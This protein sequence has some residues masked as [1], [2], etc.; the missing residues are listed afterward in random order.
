MI[1]PTNHLTIQ[2]SIIRDHHQSFQKKED[3]KTKKKLKM[4][5]FYSLSPLMLRFQWK[6]IKKKAKRKIKKK[7]SFKIAF[8]FIL[9]C[10]VFSSPIFFFLFSKRK[11]MSGSSK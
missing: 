7:N 4:L 2:P 3:E 5:P 1:Q 9:L 11:F 10:E 8:Y 6:S